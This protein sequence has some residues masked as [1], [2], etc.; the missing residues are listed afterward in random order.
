MSDEQENQ[1][2][3]VDPK[4]NIKKPNKMALNNPSADFGPNI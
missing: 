1:S 2:S 4:P 3:L